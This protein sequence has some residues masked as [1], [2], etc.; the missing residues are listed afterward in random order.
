MKPELSLAHIDSDLELATSDAELRS[1]FA[2]LDDPDQHIGTVVE[3][4]LRARG[5]FVIDPL[6]RFADSSHDA[7]A[8]RRATGIV[9]D[10]NGENLICQ[11]EALRMKLEEGRRGCLEEGAFLIARYGYPQLDVEYYK[12]ELDA[13]AGMLHDR[14]KGIHS[15]FDILL[16]TND[17][18][19]KNKKFR[20]N[21]TNFLEADNSY[22]N[23]VIDRKLGIPISLAVLYI[24]VAARRLGL[25]FSGASTPGHF[26]IRYDGL[27]DEPL[28]IDAF[29][30]GI[31]LRRE[32]IRRFVYTS[33]M[34]YYESFIQPS[35]PQNILLRMT[36]NLIILFDEQK[37][38]TAKATFERFHNILLGKDKDAKTEVFGD[39]LE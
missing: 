25:P 14:I 36:R 3:N 26:L 5:T 33:G 8:I 37:D 4:K 32:D 17:F 19:F 9:R 24:L 27:R 10:I 6:I 28:F 38:E 29:N 30:D 12:A 21:H 13:L 1:L 31:I 15:P 18:F 22:I 34:P 16:A 11:F 20:G 23:A 39:E 2:L 35:R 7:L